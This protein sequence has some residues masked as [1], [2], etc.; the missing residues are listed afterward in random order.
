MSIL[1]EVII[2]LAFIYLIFS[3][4]VSGICEL[5]QMFT[6]KRGKFLY[7]S[8]NEVFNDRLN[9]DFNFQL[10]SHPLIDRLRESDTKY[11]HYIG[12]DIFSTALI[13]T[14]RSEH[15]LPEYSFDKSEKKFV[16]KQPDLTPPVEDGNTEIFKQYLDGLN[17]LNESDLKQLLRTFAFGASDY[18]GL[19]ANVQRWFDSYMGAT[20][21][22]YKKSM[23]R[24]LMFVSLVITI[25]FNIDSIHIT[26]QLFADKNLRDKIVLNA[27][28]YVQNKQRQDSMNL[29]L[30]RDTSADRVQ[31]TVD[32][33]KKAYGEAGLLDLPI[34]WSKAQFL[35]IFSLQHFLDTIMM[36]IGWLITTAALGYGADSWFNLL[37]RLLNLR[38]SVKPKE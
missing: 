5:W 7:K 12:S 29:V 25:S 17:K 15:Q 32:E 27:D 11:P 18:A 23:T 36:I 19:K 26:K 38:T 14:I 35:L 28:N 22:W 30:Q 37:V 2:S 4:I 6:Q 20:S 1:L 31:Q 21:T 3:I 9:R 33:I 10:L 34:G 13:D 16:V 24:T 8:L